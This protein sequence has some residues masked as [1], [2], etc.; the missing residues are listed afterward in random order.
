MTG[1]ALGVF[2]KIGALIDGMRPAIA[3]GILAARAY[4]AARRKGDFGES[5]LALYGSYWSPL[6]ASYKNPVVTAL[7]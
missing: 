6:N 3:S 1:D 2:Y 7:F 4:M 5:G